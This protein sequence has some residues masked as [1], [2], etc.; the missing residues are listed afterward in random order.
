MLGACVTNEILAGLT[1]GAGGNVQL[2][3]INGDVELSGA[4]GTLVD[5]HGSTALGVGQ[6]VLS[7]SKGWESNWF[8]TDLAVDYSTDREILELSGFA[9]DRTHDYE[10]RLS[11]YETTL[12][13]AILSGVRYD[14][15]DVQRR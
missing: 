15:A 12:E 11:L 14:L 9:V 2:A 8:R 1:L 6:L 5:P 13:R 3:G 4:G 7:I 10:F